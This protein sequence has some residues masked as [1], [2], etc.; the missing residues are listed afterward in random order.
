MYGE[1]SIIVIME[2]MPNFVGYWAYIMSEHLSIETLS[3]NYE[4]R[5]NVYC[6]RLG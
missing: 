6:G 5:K 3:A 4:R 2:K 1:L